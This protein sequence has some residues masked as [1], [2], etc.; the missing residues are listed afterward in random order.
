MLRPVSHGMDYAWLSVTPFD[1]RANNPLQFRIL[2]PLLAHYLFLRGDIYVFAPLTMGGLFLSLIYFYFRKNG[3]SSGESLGV[4]SLMAFTTPISSALYFMGYVYTTSYLLLFLIIVFIRRPLVWAP[5]YSLALLNHESNLFAAPWIV[6]LENWRGFSVGRYARSLL[7]ISAALLPMV[8]YRYGVYLVGGRAIVYAAGA[9]LSWGNVR[10]V[11]YP[12]AYYMWAGVFGAFKLLWFFP[13]YAIYRL[14]GVRR[15]RREVAW[16]G[17]IIVCAVSQL[18]IASDVTR[19]MGLAF[20]AVL[21]GAKAVRDVW[22]KEVFARR[23]WLLIG[24]N[25]LV[26]HYQVVAGTLILIQPL[27]VSLALKYIF[28]VGVVGL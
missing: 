18:L 12:G 16:L 7:L 26:P 20:P 22:G 17:L 27:P 21:F 9:Y 15:R 23:L 24:F 8:L 5:L 4:V 10:N 3:F 2:T 13:L 25:F 1:F 28:G 11:F 6:M 14:V 19:L